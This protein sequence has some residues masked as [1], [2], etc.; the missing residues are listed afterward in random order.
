MVTDTEVTFP[1]ASETV[2]RIQAV[3]RNEVSIYVDARR[4]TLDLFDDD[5]YANVFLVGI[6]C[7]AG[8]LPLKT[9]SIEE[10]ITLNGV[11]VPSNIQAFRLGRQYVADQAAV[12]TAIAQLRTP[13]PMAAPH[14]DAVEIAE[15]VGADPSSELARLVSSG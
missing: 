11:A 15:L 12:D 14:P 2:G 5:Q 4:Y 1:N 13:R 8:A 7:Q 9:S 3:T 6:A 10:A